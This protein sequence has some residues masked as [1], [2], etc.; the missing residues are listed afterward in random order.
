[1][2]RFDTGSSSE[3]LLA[4]CADAYM[5]G[6]AGTRNVLAVA[7][8]TGVSSTTVASREST[9]VTIEAATKTRRSSRLPLP[10]LPRPISSP[11]Q[12][13]TPAASHRSPTTRIAARKSTTGSRRLISAS[14]S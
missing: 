8:T 14:A 11:A 13:N 9:A 10:P 6:L 4:R 2:V 5:W 7:S 1:L 12:R 3:A